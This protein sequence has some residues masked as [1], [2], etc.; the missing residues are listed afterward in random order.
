[1]LARYSL[2]VAMISAV[3]RAQ[4]PAA[5]PNHGLRA[6]VLNDRDRLAPR[7]EHF[8]AALDG[9]VF[10]RP[11]GAHEFYYGVGYWL[12]LRSEVAPNEYFS[13]NLRTILYAGSCSFGYAAPGGMYNLLSV[14]V[15]WP[16]EVA[17]GVLKARALDLERQTFGVGLFI[18]DRE[19]NGA[20][21]SWNSD[22]FGLLLRGNGTGGLHTE[23]DTYDAELSLFDGKLGLGAAYNSRPYSYL[24]SKWPLGDDFG[25][26]FE[27]GSR[28]R[29]WAAMAALKH[30]ARW[31]SLQLKSSAEGRYYPQGFARDFSQNIQKEYV[32]YDQYDKRFTDPLNVFVWGEDAAVYA[33]TID[34]LYRLSP[35]WAFE[36]LNELG[37]FDYVRERNVRYYF[38]RL[39]ASYYPF[40]TREDRL[41]LFA[42]D[43]FLLD[44]YAR[45]PWG[46][47]HQNEATFRQS[48]IY[49]AL[50]GNFKL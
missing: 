6:E 34:A 46:S 31:A 50:E 44:S 14:S 15:T 27:S 24:F 11:T 43:K 30:S 35:H 2:L 40:D 17:G 3:A 37:V 23:Y 28:A 29:K 12:Q 47:S 18:Q 49:V 25:L 9:N 42:S 33:G 1:M 48:N 39:G 8:A 21:L 16:S 41:T 13:A 4:Y 26:E 5:L 7:W 10:F 38:F 19:F 36:S 45:P 22:H 32:A 20:L